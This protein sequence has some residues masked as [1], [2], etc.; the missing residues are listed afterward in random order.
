MHAWPVQMHASMLMTCDTCNVNVKPHSQSGQSH[1]YTRAL[2]LVGLIMLT[3]D[4]C[5]D[6]MQQQN[7]PAL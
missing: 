7:M 2:S 1:A 4:G 6:Q 3:S 5:Q